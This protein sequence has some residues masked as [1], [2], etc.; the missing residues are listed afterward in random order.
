[1]VT[2]ASLGLWWEGLRG[3][4][5]FQCRQV[6]VEN[7][8]LIHIRESDTSPSSWTKLTSCLK[9]SIVVPSYW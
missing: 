8:R 6:E 3:E 4:A 1:M 7:V 9:Y 5:E 2:Q